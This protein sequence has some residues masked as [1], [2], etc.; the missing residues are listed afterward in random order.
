MRQTRLTGFLAALLI[1]ACWPVAAQD[2]GNCTE[3][4]AWRGDGVGHA[5]IREER[6]AA[7]PETL[8]DPAMNGSIR[9]HGWANADIRVKACVQTFAQDAGAALA[10]AR[11]VTI[12]DGPGRV[13]AKGP[14]PA[15][16]AWWSVS[17]EVWAPSSANLELKADNGSI[18]VDG[19]NGAVRAHTLNGSLKLKNLSGDVEG[20]TTNGSLSVDLA[21]GGWQGKGMKLNTTNGSINMRLAQG[22]SADVEASTVNGRIHSDLA[23]ANVNIEDKHDAKFTLGAGGAKIEARTVNGSVRISGAI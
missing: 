12:T 23:A 15:D 10:L 5:E 21:S 6:L 14:T 20:E 8:I 1:A 18:S 19:M 22:I 11:Q 2:S 9:V 3:Q 16:Q 17:Y 4:H 13:V 7:A